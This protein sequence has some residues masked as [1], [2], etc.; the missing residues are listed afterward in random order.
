LD[1][2]SHLQNRQQPHLI[3]TTRTERFQRKPNDG[4]S[5]EPAEPEEIIKF[6]PEEEAVRIMLQAIQLHSQ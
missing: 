1:I 4:S 5:A 3:M 2:A 6:S